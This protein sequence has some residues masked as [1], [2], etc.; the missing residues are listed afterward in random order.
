MAE[1]KKTLAPSTERLSVVMPVHN[2]LPHLDAAVRSILGQ[3]HGDFEFVIL[4]DASTD[5]SSE[6]L[7]DWA[8][9]DQRIRLIRSER[10]LGPVASSNR[11]VQGS[12]GNIVARMDAD[13][14]AHPDRLRRQIELLRANPEVGLVG[15]LCEVID[16]KGR[17]LRDLEIWRLLRKTS[18]AP[19]PH[20][21][22]MY[23]RHLYD[24]VGGYRQGCEFWE[25]QDFVWR[26]A[27]LA[28]ILVIPTALFMVRHSS[29]STRIASEQEGVEQAVDLMYRCT[30]RLEAG[31][32]YDDLLASDARRD[33]VDPRVFISLGSLRLWSGETPHQF[34]R[35]LR[36]SELRLNFKSVAAIVWTAW[37][38]ASPATLRAFLGLLVRIRTALARRVIRSDAPLKW[39]PRHEAPAPARLEPAVTAKPG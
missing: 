25:D 31:Q 11:V 4:D 14:I 24:K 34:A 28:E 27:G 30:A 19:F 18:M 12:S 7:A 3:T 6:R 10:N 20:G 16:G 39:A 33:R 26:L 1:M 21:S 15:T 9:R 8:A 37:A 5:G 36:R 22:F 38:S 23:R 35:L 2:A 13:D 29:T 17:K 32:S